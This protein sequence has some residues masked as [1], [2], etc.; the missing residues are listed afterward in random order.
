MEDG[1]GWLAGAGGGWRLEQAKW[2]EQVEARGWSMLAG[3]SKWRLGLYWL[4]I[5]CLQIVLV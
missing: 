1:E 5:G 2:L 4:A 3:W